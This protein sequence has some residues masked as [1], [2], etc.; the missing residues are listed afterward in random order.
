MA[1]MRYLWRE[2]ISLDGRK[3]EAML[4][5]D[6]P[7][8]PLETAVRDTLVGLGCIKASGPEDAGSKDVF[9]GYCADEPTR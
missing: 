2:S 3:L 6:L 4:G 5:D 8:T 7:R 9:A 1:E